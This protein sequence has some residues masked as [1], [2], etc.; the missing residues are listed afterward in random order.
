LLFRL[1]TIAPGIR[2]WRTAAL[3]ASGLAALVWQIMSR[4]FGWWAAGDM[5]HY[6]HI[7]GSLATLILMM[8]WMYLSAIIILA[9]AHLCAAIQS[10]YGPAGR[11][12]RNESI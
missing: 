5:A 4:I 1:Y 6:Q 10:H 9:G 2:V 11:G 7:Y 12:G 3:L 8:M